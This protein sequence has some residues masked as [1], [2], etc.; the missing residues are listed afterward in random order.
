MFMSVSANPAAPGPFDGDGSNDPLQPTPLAT[1]AMGVWISGQVSAVDPDYFYITAPSGMRFKSLTIES[2]RSVDPIAFIAI[3]IGSQF[4]AGYD[5]TKMLFGRHIGA[6]DVNKNLLDGLTD[7]A[8]EGIVM[9]VNQTGAL[10]DYI[11]AARFEVAQGKNIY[12]TV[13]SESIKGTDAPERIFGVGGDD[14]IQGGLRDDTIDGGE[15]LDTAVFSNRRE[16]YSISI[17]EQNAVSVRFEGPVIAIYPP[18]P[19]DGTDLLSSIERIQFSD[20]SVAMDLD[21]NAGNAARL[22]AAV[23]G[24]DAVKNPTYAGIA[25]SLFDQGYSKDQVS[26]VA[27]NAMFGANVKSKDIVSMIWMNLIGSAID[28]KNL[29]DLIGLIDS[30]AITAA[31]L[32]TKAADLDL[33]AQIIDLVGLSKTGW[34]YVPYGG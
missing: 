5:T 24:K 7:K 21:N 3:Q 33:T 9:W 26:Q 30:K 22:L 18:P 20:R 17:L 32:T 10:T 27:L 29:A 11:I 6:D 12:G 2:Y 13:K 34:E 19:T 8:Q 23:F 31:Q 4:T 16:S 15:G 1:S 25:I 28:D 14:T